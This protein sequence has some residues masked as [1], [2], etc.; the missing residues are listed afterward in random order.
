MEDISLHILD[1][2]EN[3]VRAGASLVKIQIDED[4]KNDQLVVRIEDNGQ[5]MKEQELENSLNPFFT[6]KKDKKIGLGLSLFH[7]AARIAGGNLEITTRENWG[8]KIKAVFQH[9]HI[10]RKPLGSIKNT[11]EILVI[12]NSHVDFIYEH[13]KGEE[14]IAF[15]TRKLRDGIEA[16]SLYPAVMIKKIQQLFINGHK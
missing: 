7:D 4:L 12:G 11:I 15:D 1:I 2:A 9:S 13:R 16:D 14:K 10:D 5:G 6:T 3:S 8:T